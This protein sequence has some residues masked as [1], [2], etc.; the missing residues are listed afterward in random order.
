MVYSWR[1]S[2]TSFSGVSVRISIACV[3]LLVAGF[4]SGQ[5][6]GQ[7]PLDDAR[8]ILKAMSD[9]V[10]G[11]ETIDLAFDSAIEVITPELEKLQ[12]TSSG[13]ALVSRPDKIPPPTEWAGFPRWSSSLTAL[14]R[15]STE[16]ASTAMRSLRS[17]QDPGRPH[18]RPAC[19]P[20]R[21]TSRCGPVVVKLVRG[22]GRR[23]AR[24]KVPRPRR[25]SRGDVWSTWPSATSTPT[26]RSGWGGGRRART[27]EAGDHQ[28]DREQ[29]TPV[30]RGHHELEDW[31]RHRIGSLCIHAIG[32]RRADS[33]PTR[34]S[35]STSCPRNTIWEVENEDFQE[36]HAVGSRCFRSRV[37]SRAPR[38]RQL[39]DARPRQ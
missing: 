29:R 34:S 17:R 2:S 20:R 31:S 18:P 26:G 15:A 10:S 3:V 23:R 11:Q 35:S 8:A 4:A 27:P 28:Q 1:D 21:R 5:G 32:R 38:S 22:F 25:S 16:R 9:Y 30:Q 7:E 36:W 14:P 39:Q 13:S 19:G 24:G 6:T 12:F 33:T 37:F